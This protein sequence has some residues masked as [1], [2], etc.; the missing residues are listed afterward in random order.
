[1]EDLVLSDK[2]HQAALTTQLNEYTSLRGMR[3]K[4]LEEDNEVFLS[5]FHLHARP[6][7]IKQTK[8]GLHIPYL[9]PKSTLNWY[10]KQQCE[11]NEKPLPQDVTSRFYE[12]CCLAEHQPK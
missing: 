10:M 1:M 11:D 8:S 3:V 2:S 7:L 6:R 9:G 12:A 5:G 4:V